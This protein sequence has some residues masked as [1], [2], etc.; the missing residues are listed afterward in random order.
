MYLENNIVLPPVDI[1]IEISPDWKVAEELHS[2]HL[3]PHPAGTDLLL[4]WPV[5][6][7]KADP[8]GHLVL[9]GPGGDGQLG[10]LAQ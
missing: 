3:S 2:S 6:A 7:V 1:F 8:G 10:Q 4:D 9:L 5:L